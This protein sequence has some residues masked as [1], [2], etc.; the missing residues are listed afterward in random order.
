VGDACYAVA[1]PWYVLAAHGGTALL[2]TVLVAYGI[3]RTGLIVAGGWASDRWNAQTVMMATDA[4]RCLG[5][6]GLAAV[7]ALGSAHAALLI[8]IAVVLGAGEGLFLPA[9]YAVLPSIVPAADLQAANGLTT[10]GAQLAT[11]AGPAIGGALVALGSPALAFALDAVSFAASAATLARLR[12]VALTPDPAEPASA[13]PE[14]EPADADSAGME[15]GAAVPT[16]TFALI[17]SQRVLQLILLLTI[18]A[19]LGS[20]GVDFVSLPA[21]AHGPLH[22]G[23][24]GY[25]LILAGFGAGALLGALLAGQARPPRRPAVIAVLAFQVSAVCTLVVPYLGSTPGVAGVMVIS[26]AAVSFGNVLAF[27]AFQRWAPPAVLGRASGALTLGIFGV[28][29][30]SVALAAVFTRDLGPSA[31][32]LFSAIALT[33]AIVFGLTQRAWRDFGMISSSGL[34][35]SD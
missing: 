13:L 15:A 24:A 33:A 25:G 9:S 6:A 5:V 20:D 32:F 23:A 22:S 28:Y 34:E 29:P 2:G 18:T 30:L 16:S 4:T 11:L 21:L 17:R 35:S 26:G 10:S 27:A 7:A 12:A 19:N 3:P 14:A 8:P 31:F 1:L